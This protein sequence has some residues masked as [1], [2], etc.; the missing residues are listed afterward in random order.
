MFIKK[1]NKN[2]LIVVGKVYWEY[3][4]KEKKKMWKL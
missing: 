3:M 2:K 1:G 4:E